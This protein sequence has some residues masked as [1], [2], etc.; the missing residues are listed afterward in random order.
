MASCEWGNCEVSWVATG[1]IAQKLAYRES[2]GAGGSRY[3][4]CASSVEALLGLL[5]SQ[6][7]FLTQS[8]TCKLQQEIPQLF[9]HYLLMLFLSFTA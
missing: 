7:G 8:S 3:R 1:A 9:P 6:E 2:P 4:G 5:C